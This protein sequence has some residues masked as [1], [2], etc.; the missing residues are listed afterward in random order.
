MIEKPYILGIETTCDETAVGIVMPSHESR[1]RVLA[2]TVF[3][4]I[5]AH[6][7]YGGVVPEIA[8]R[9]HVE[10]LDLLIQDALSQASLEL[11]DI[12][13]FAVSAGPGLVGSLM[14]GLV[15]AKTLALICHKPL[16]GVNHLEAHL[17]SPRIQSTLPFP[18]LAL[19]VSGGHTQLV[20]VHDVGHYTTL[21]TTL[22]DALGEAFDKTAK[23]MGLPY[24]G[25][26]HVERFAKQGNPHRFVFP[27]PLWGTQKPDFSFSG[28]KT[29]VRLAIE[30]TVPLSETDVSDLCASFQYAIG[31]VLCDRVERAFALF[32]SVDPRPLGGFTIVGGVASNDTLRARLAAQAEMRHIPF[33][34]PPK[35]Y[36][37]DN[38]AMIAW[39]GL[40][41][42][43]RGLLD[44]LEIPIRARWPIEEVTYVI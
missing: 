43:Q 40:E 14:V 38:G 23:M 24:P 35:E 8:A 29:A 13:G 19:L 34:L 15:T 11:G 32:S 9:A 44:S 6:A 31:Q 33:I 42:F 1:E 36:C 3:S 41:R 39:A 4:Q 26:P 16:I 21:G 22:D 27:K 37:T 17:L 18:Y 20:A 12:N 7:I 30:Q 2:H 10:R 25:G 28:L 5:D